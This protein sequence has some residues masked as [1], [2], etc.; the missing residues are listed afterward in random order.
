M[1]SAVP[2]DATSNSAG[3]SDEFFLVRNKRGERA[4]RRAFHA[5]TNRGIARLAINLLNA[6]TQSKIEGVAA[7]YELIAFLDQLCIGNRN[8]LF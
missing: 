5:F 7:K 6:I 1:Q 3:V 2:S 8:R 4:E